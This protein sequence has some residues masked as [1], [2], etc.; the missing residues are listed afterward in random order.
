[1][2]WIP[3]IFLGLGIVPRDVAFDVKVPLLAGVM[4]IFKC[5]V[6]CITTIDFHFRL[7]AP[8]IDCT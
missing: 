6:P 3:Y 8:S 5:D 2:D 4:Q 1:M 7:D